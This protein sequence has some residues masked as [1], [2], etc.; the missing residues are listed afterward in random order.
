M[1]SAIPRLSILHR[2]WL[3]RSAAV[4]ALATVC[5]AA[6]AAGDPRAS[7]LYEDALQRFD[8]KDYAGAVIQL[9]NALQI[10]KNMLPV[11]VLLGKALLEQDQGAAAEAALLEALRL[12]ASREEV[13]VSLARVTIEMGKP[14]GVLDDERFSEQGLSDDNRFELLMLKARAADLVGDAKVA[15]QAVE[16]ARIAAPKSEAPWVV[17]AKIRLRTRQIAEALVAADKAISLAPDKAEP[18]YVRGTI[19]HAKGDMKAALL[20]YDKALRIEPNH[21]EALVSRSGVLLDLGRRADAQ[22]DIEALRLKDPTDPRGAYLMALIAERDGRGAEAKAELNKVTARLDS[23]PIEALRYRPQLLMLG[24]LAHFG[25]GQTEKAKPYLEGVLRAEPT[26]PAAKLIGQI[27]VDEGNHDRAIAALEPY[28]RHAP[29]D[30][31]ATLLY[32]SAL[33]AKGW[34]ARAI[35]ELKSAKQRDPRPAYMHALGMAYMKSGEFQS[36]LAE[37]EAAYKAAPKA[38]AP[39]S[40]LASLYLQLGQP[41]RAAQLAD[42]LTKV[43]KDQP[44]LLF[45]L[46]KARLEVGDVKGARTALEAAAKTDPRF[47]DPQVELAKLDLVSGATMAAKTRLSAALEKAPK[48]AELLWLTGQVM[49]AEG[50]LTE[51]IQWFE[52][53]DSHSAPEVVDYGMRLV[54][55]HL[56]QGQVDKAR[57][58]AKRLTAK[59][60][61]APRVLVQLARID[62]AAG[63]RKAA[64]STLARASTAFGTDAGSL[65]LVAE[66]QLAADDVAG[67]AHSASKALK[68]S[69]QHIG[70]QVM[71]T[72]AEI[73][74]G[75]L[76]AAE[77]RARSIVTR[78]PRAG[79]G[80]TLL[81][82]LALARKQDG[83]AAAE[84]RRAHELD[85]NR[86]TLMRLFGLLTRTQAAEANRLAEQWVK[87]YPSDVVVL[88]ALGDAQSRGADWAAARRSYEALL[89][90]SPDDAEALN[91]LAH[92]MLVQRDAQ[93]L[94]TAERALA[95][96]PTAPHIIGTVG[97]AAHKSGQ[98]DRALQLLRDARLRNPDSPETRYYLGATLAAMGRTSEAKT[99]LMAAVKSPR[100]FSSLKDAQNLLS[101]LN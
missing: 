86:A 33:L 100:A 24:G 61:D 17:E 28:R 16:A 21:V 14:R 13:V 90:S 11:H 70:A 3:R 9:K 96:N 65:A 23:L 42:A 37:L 52:K 48:H 89:K 31:Q 10:D 74:Q 81:G 47:I 55:F 5:M 6:V 20:S 98:N 54:E 44:G 32:C 71:L 95:L 76:P 22:R 41:G 56:A 83:A 50:R 60:P 59:L 63:D 93:A 97:W 75:S 38:I 1:S 26:S 99:E 82:E 34:T 36:A 12:G 7:R 91:N 25:L 4:A 49:A 30:V 68:E 66:L 101:T 18:Q 8:K 45:L 46:G 27:H 73:L 15:M 77:Q 80:H 57:D 62:L 51:A 29:A 35:N 53:A 84:F 94:K 40:A 79:I 85:N 43:N 67:A 88:R 69:P 2:A 39:G 92:V 72:R 19:A 87:R 64:K 58:A 78:H